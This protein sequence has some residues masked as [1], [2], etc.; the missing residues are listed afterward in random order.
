MTLIVYLL[1]IL[2][3]YYVGKALFSDYGGNDDSGWSEPDKNGVR[4]KWE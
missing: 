2:L 3:V 4:Y 1:L